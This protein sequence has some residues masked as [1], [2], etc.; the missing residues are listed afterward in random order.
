MLS[1]NGQLIGLD[2]GLMCLTS[3]GRGKGEKK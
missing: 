3:P 2:K 1:I